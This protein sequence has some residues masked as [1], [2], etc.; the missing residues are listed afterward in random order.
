M[1]LQHVLI[2]GII[3][4]QLQGVSLSFFEFH[5][6]AV[7][8]VSPALPDLSEWLYKQLLLSP[9]RPS[10]VPSVSDCQLFLV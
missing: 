5:E 8:P 9:A 3:P 7:V 4:S 2:C 6:V 1:G 10:L